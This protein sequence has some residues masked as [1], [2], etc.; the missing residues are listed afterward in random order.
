[1]AARL[2]LANTLAHTDS[3]R[4]T[5]QMPFRDVVTKKHR[6]FRDDHHGNQVSPRDGVTKTAFLTT[7]Y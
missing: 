7:M 6:D 3:L 2:R 1:M 5:V 4:Q